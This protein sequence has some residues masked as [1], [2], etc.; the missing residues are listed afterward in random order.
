VLIPGTPAGDLQQAQEP[1]G[2]RVDFDRFD[3]KIDRLFHADPKT[4]NPAEMREVKRWIRG[5]S[6]KFG[7][8]NQGRPLHP[9]EP[10]DQIAAQLLTI[11]PCT[12]IVALIQDLMTERKEPGQS[13]SWY[14]TVA[15]QRIAGIKPEDLK[16][17]RAQ[18]RIA[19]KR[20]HD[21]PPPAPEPAADD[22]A[23][24]LISSVA[25]TMK[26]KGA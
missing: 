4:F 8:D 17:A 7:K 16:E 13:Y 23:G 26:A 19:G 15:A 6:A 22:F 9:H 10:D 3:L 11:A 25:R 18:L 21:P 24:E 14:V 2:A 5:Y 1:A 12:R 20:N